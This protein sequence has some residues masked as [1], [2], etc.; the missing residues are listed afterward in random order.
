M[1]C[2][3]PR[4]TLSPTFDHSSSW[5]R[6]AASVRP[7]RKSIVEIDICKERRSHRT[8]PCSSSAKRQGQT[9]TRLLKIAIYLSDLSGGGAERLQINLA[10]FFLDRGMSV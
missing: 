3:F 9:M 5:P 6:A 7:K 2:R 8:L 4:F 10:Q 1:I